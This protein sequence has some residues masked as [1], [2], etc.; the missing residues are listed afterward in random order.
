VAEQVG[1][2]YYEVDLDT[3][4]LLDSNRAVRRELNGATAT[5]DGFQSKLT[6]TAAAA[7]ALGAALLAMKVAQR[8]DEFRLLSA[9]VDVAAGSMESGAAAF[10][11][12][13]DISR[14]T[15]SSL[16]GNIEVFT[17]LNQSLM[18]MGGTQRDT[19]QVTELLAKAIKVSGA[20]AVEAKAAVLQFGQ[21]L[22]SGKL[23]GDELRSLLETAPYLMRQLAD[24][25]GVPVGSLKTLGEQGKLTADVVV[26]AL[27]KAAA[28]IDADFKK[29]PQTIE[30]AMVVAADQASLAAIKFDELSGGSQALTG[31]IKGASEVFDELAKQLGAANEEAGKLGRNDAVRSWADAARNALSYLADAADI[32]WQTLSVLGRNVTFVF[33][34]IG[35]EIGGLAAQAISVAKGDFAG[36]AAIGQAMKADAE[37]RRRELDAADAK[38]LARTKLAGQQMREAW[39]QG[40]GGGRGSVIPGG[41]A[42]KLKPPPGAGGG[43]A[44][45][46]FD[47]A[48]Y[49]AG[50]AKEV[51]TEYQKVDVIEREALRKNDA[52]LAQKKISVEQHQKAI[53]LIEQNAA[54]DR[55]AIFEK[56]SSEAIARQIEYGAAE[57][58]NAL[59]LA[60]QRKRTQQAAIDIKVADDPIARLQIE[61]ER[62]KELLAQYAADDQANEQ[63][64]AEAAV[65][66][67]Q[68]TQDR[69]RQIREKEMA[70]RAAAQSA[71][72]TAYGNLFGSMADI[73]KAFS[74]KQSGIYKAMFAA[75]KAFALADAA[76]KIQQG[77]AGAAALPFPA[78]LAAIGSVVAATSSILSTISGVSYGGGRQYGGPVSA[79][80]LYRVNETGRP[81]MFTGSNGNQYLLPTKS[82]AVTPANQVGAGGGGGQPWNIIIQNA[83]PGTRASVDDQSRT[84]QIAVGEVAS[85]ISNNNGPVWSALRG[86]STIGPRQ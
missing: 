28:T 17:R 77:I 42:G 74:G 75:S 81:E 11:D 60:E 62:K 71:Q 45:A 27:T 69:I 43:K 57:E 70:D 2:I 3:K 33:K 64:Y 10:S 24:G 12:L 47:G 44:G 32:T 7:A 19:L 9:R 59:K 53:T 39:E 63:L 34:G 31:V 65:A 21:A 23:A 36:A 48:A 76:I 6:A 1:G 84:V 37:Q 40:A 52:L 67:E 20:S 22:G 78:N 46:Q 30:A 25:I 38:T 66:L 61:L 15:Q 86:A 13:V 80:S 16:A 26:N 79:G 35:A 8:A 5:L 50:L 49:I 83:P 72:L 18:Q 4:K 82:G 51:A 55:A 68:Q 41:P 73:A 85:Q 14:R 56:Q 29:F 54:Q 58:A